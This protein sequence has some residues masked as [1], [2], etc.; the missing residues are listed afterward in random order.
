MGLLWLLNGR[1]LVMMGDAAAVI[2]SADGVCQ[3][4]R[5]LAAQPGRVLAWEILR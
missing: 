5:R 4:Y 2:E 1:R 3:T